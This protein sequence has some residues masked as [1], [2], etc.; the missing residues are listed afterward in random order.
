MGRRPIS[1]RAGDTF[2]SAEPM[3][4]LGLFGHLATRFSASPEN[5]ATESLAYVLDSSVASRT[6]VDFFRESADVELDTRFRFRTQSAGGDGSIPD[7]VGIDSSGHQSLVVEAKFWAGL[8]DQQ[9]LGYLSRLPAGRPAVLAFVGPAGRVDF[10]WRELRR[11]CAEGAVAL[12]AE[13]GSTE[14]R[15]AELNDQ[16][17]LVVVSWRRLLDVVA[18]AVEAA[19]EDHIVA[20]IAQLEG[21]CER[22]DE[23]A[24]LPLRSEELSSELAFRITDYGHL[25]NEVVDRLV[26]TG[27][28]SV[29]G[30]RASGGFGWFGRPVDIGP[31][32]T[33]FGFNARKWTYDAATPLWI[34]IYGP[35]WAEPAAAVREALAPL[36]FVD[37]P[38]LFEADGHLTVPLY[39]PAGREWDDVVDDLVR[40]ALRVVALLETTAP[41]ASTE[42]DLPTAGD[43]PPEQ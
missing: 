30:R 3:T 35:R 16:H 20:D 10:L 33:F 2:L 12:G 34:S 4:H 41:P 42:A 18:R 8:T 40:Q 26:E 9:P 19:G 6:L 7:L 32:L 43:T 37:P 1:R 36:E 27:R 38:M 14:L 25:V 28:V 5:L 21:L 23:D 17:R 13:R 24:F 29:T 31:V 11:R 15:V 22:M 39:P